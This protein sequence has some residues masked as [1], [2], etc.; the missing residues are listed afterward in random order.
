MLTWAQGHFPW[1]S[2]TIHVDWKKDG[3]RI[4]LEVELPNELE[5]ELVLPRKDSKDVRLVHNGKQVDLGRGARTGL[6]IS[7]KTVAIRVAG[8]KHRLELGPTT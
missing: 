6:L 8:G 5:A 1:K 7:E 3:T 4:S 2:G